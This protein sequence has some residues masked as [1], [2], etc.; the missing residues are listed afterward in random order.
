M[1][2]FV[3]EL[4]TVVLGSDGGRKV[5]GNHLKES[6]TGREPA[7][8]HG[9]H[10]GLTLEGLLLSIELNVELLDELGGNV[11]L[12]VHDGVEDLVD[13]VQDEH[14]ETA[15][16]AIVKGL[17]P[18]L[19][20][21][22][23]ELVTPETTHHLLNVNAKLVRVHLGK[24]LEGKGPAVETRA[25]TDGTLGHIDLDGTH[26]T[27]II[28]VG[29]D[30]DVDALNDTLE[31][32]VE[33]FL[34]EL[35]LEKSAVHLVHEK[36]GLDAL[37]NGLTE[38]SLGLHAHTRDAIDDDKSTIGNTES[39]SHFRGEI[40]VS[41]R[42]NEVDQESVTLDLGLDEGHVLLLKLVVQGD[43]GG[44]D[45]NATL[46]LV[47]TSIGEAGLTGLGTSNDTGLGHEGIGQSG[48][49]VIDVG[50]HRHVTDVEPLVHDLT[51]LVD[52]EVHHGWLLLS[53]VNKKEGG[54]KG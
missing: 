11:M 8:H 17:A 33:I 5:D 4:H 44:L 52:C 40:D 6:L 49:A 12:E 35:E 18:L 38:H 48:L 13:G 7:A 23:E 41:G 50:N 39:S 27:I 34:L 36:N 25:E 3:E 43:G 42:V 26:G 37:S 15:L 54:W 1:R 51:D 19:G 46:L 29:G 45:G 22:V 9:L 31:G 14:A 32:L 21:W 2:A 16:V 10:E 28:T 20:A 53:R 24:L 47:S 30:N